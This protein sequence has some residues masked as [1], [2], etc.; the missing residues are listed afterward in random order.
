MMRLRNPLIILLI[1]LAA[2]SGCSQPPSVRPT[3][4]PGRNAPTLSVTQIAQNSFGTA[5][6]SGAVKGD[7]AEFVF[8]APKEGTPAER[9]RR[10]VIMAA[11]AI[12]T[13]LRCEPNVKVMR[14]TSLDP[15]QDS[16]KLAVFT[17]T[18]E[19]SKV[20]GGHGS[21]DALLPVVKMEYADP[22]FK[23]A[24]MQSSRK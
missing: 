23:E 17:V 14:F 13:T 8:S 11:T 12:P 6:R 7:A 20:L 22:E 21:P 2:L 1:P 5:Y 10:S 16:R 3:P 9:F 15:A 24:T 19:D 18:R 4:S